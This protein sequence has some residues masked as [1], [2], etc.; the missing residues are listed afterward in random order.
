MGG[1]QSILYAEPVSE[2]KEGETPVYRF[3]DFKN[4]LIDAPEK[5]LKTMKDILINSSKK[6]ANRN[7]LGTI[8]A[9]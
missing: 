7:A 9:K 3:P 6:Y 4:G 5:H 8:V 2:K 1:G